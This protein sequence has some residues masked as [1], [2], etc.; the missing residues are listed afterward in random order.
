MVRLLLA[1]RAGELIA[2]RSG[3]CSSVPTGNADGSS[4]K[5]TGLT[6]PRATTI[7]SARPWG[8]APMGHPV[9][10]TSVGN[11]AQEYQTL[12]IQGPRFRVAAVIKNGRDEARPSE[13][14]RHPLSG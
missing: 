13:R 10:P 6:E 7:A 3:N 5:R 12:Q 1:M 4:S 9:V 11:H 14:M 2:H 8:H